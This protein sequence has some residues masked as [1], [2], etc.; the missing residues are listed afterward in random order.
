MNSIRSWRSVARAL[1]ICLAMM[2]A[3]AVQAHAQDHPRARP[4]GSAALATLP[5]A[6]NPAATSVACT[7][8]TPCTINAGQTATWGGN[9]SW[10]YIGGVL[11]LDTIREFLS[12]TPAGATSPPGYTNFFNPNPYMISIPTTYFSIGLQTSPTTEGGQFTLTAY[13]EGTFCGYYAF[14]PPTTQLTILAPTATPTPVVTVN[15]ADLVSNDVSVTLTD[16]S[17]GATGAL[18]VTANGASNTYPATGLSGAVAPGTYSVSFN[19]TEMPPDVYSSVTAQWTVNSNAVTTIYTLPE[20]WEVLGL[21]R[22]SQ[23]NVPVQSNQCKG[24]FKPAWVVDSNCVYKKTHLQSNFMVQTNLNGTGSSEAFGL[25][26]PFLTT[27]AP[28]LCANVTRP[29]G[30]KVSNNIKTNN[31]FFMVPS[32]TGS[33]GPDLVKESSVATFPNPKI[34]TSPNAVCDD[35]ILLVQASQANRAVKDVGDFCPAC[36]QQFLGTN[37]HIDNLTS[38]SACNGHSITDL[39]NYR[40][41]DTQGQNN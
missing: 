20:D 26:K 16:L 15:S 6:I 33:C 8:N 29:K 24:A 25:V 30:S 18:T 19:R 23:Y 1:A 11:Q 2:P 12:G 35:S 14:N 4:N 9:Y 36:N 17:N 38:S 39:G 10:C 28:T 7:Y 32:I 21:V 5:S 41:A 22:H 40:T 13:G 37:G 31:T 3:V 34:S 27:R